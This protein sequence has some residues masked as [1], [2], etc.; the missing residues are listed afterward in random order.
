M[1]LCIILCLCK[2]QRQN[3]LKIRDQQ[4]VATTEQYSIYLQYLSMGQVYSTAPKSFRILCTPGTKTLKNCRNA[5]YA[6]KAGKYLEISNRGRGERVKTPIPRP[7]I[8]IT[9][10]S[11]S[12][13]TFGE[14][15]IYQGWT[16]YS[17]PNFLNFPVFPLVFFPVFLLF[18]PESENMRH[19]GHFDK[20]SNV[21][22]NL[23]IPFSIVETDKC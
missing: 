16:T 23:F 22:L 13:R 19:N 7:S 4:L 18:S 3:R 1:I 14:L 6:P 21:L 2:F 12:E 15:M 10:M 20:V 9:V 8:Q 11:K 17:N 5:K